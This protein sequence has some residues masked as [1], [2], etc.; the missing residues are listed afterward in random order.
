MN[1]QRP[2]RAVVGQPSK[3]YSAWSCV[4][5]AGWEESGQRAVLLH[6]DA[7]GAI[8]E[9]GLGI[10]LIDDDGLIG[11]TVAIRVPWLCAW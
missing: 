4:C 10:V 5:G 7:D 3:G 11:R 1:R 2:R 8:R 6:E 9:L